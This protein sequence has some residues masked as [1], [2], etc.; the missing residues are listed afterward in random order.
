MLVVNKFSTLSHFVKLGYRKQWEMCASLSHTHSLNPS[1]SPQYS[2][3]CH[4]EA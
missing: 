3:Q 1:G 4:G 2:R